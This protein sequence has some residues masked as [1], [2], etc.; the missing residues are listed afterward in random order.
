MNNKLIS[1]IVPVY[2]SEFYL[3][4][5]VKSILSQ[6]FRDIEVILVDD[7][8][9][10][11]SGLLCD[12]LA[13]ED[14]RVKVIHKANGGVSS[15]RN[16][17]MNAASGQYLAFVDADDWL[18]VRALEKLYNCISA[19]EDPDFCFGNFMYVGVLSRTVCDYSHELICTRD[20]ADNFVEYLYMLEN[21]HTCWGKLYKSEII[22]N[23]NLLFRESVSLGEDTLFLFEY[24][25]C[26]NRFAMVPDVVYCYSKLVPSSASSRYFPSINRLR[27]ELLEIYEKA[28][29]VAKAPGSLTELYFLRFAWIAFSVVCGHYAAHLDKDDGTEKI[30]ETYELLR[31]YLTTEISFS[32]CGGLKCDSLITDRIIPCF[33][34]KDEI[35]FAAVYDC[36]SEPDPTVKQKIRN[37]LKN[38]LMPISRFW[39]YQLNADDG[40]DKEIKR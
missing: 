30:K 12:R 39:V 38:L 29:M 16:V 31:H 27:R 13:A 28:L 34:G 37:G 23:H 36:F 3:K 32:Q 26:C 8:S 5:C 7:G 17:G 2:N 25:C 14:D 35:D 21:S 24:L 6:T 11:K 18:P 15:A 1:V 10:D 9:A 20:D 4:K 19:P 40:I 33:D 22:K